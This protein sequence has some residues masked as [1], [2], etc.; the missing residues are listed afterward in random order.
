[1]A[2]FN[3][4]GAF[5]NPEDFLRYKTREKKVLDELKI[6]GEVRPETLE[7]YLESEKV[8]ESISNS[9]KNTEIKKRLTFVSLIK[10]TYLPRI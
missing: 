5:K 3:H 1:M 4:T 9:V 8:I 6:H 10:L 2:T 7:S